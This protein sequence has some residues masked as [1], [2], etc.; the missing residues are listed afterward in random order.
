MCMMIKRGEGFA[1]GGMHLER[2][3]KNRKGEKN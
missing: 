1:F 2:K 3:K